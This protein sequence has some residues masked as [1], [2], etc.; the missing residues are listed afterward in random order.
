MKLRIGKKV[1]LQGYDIHALSSKIDCTLQSVLD[2]ALGC[3]VPIFALEDDYE[4]R[5]VVQQPENVQW[6][7]DQDYILDLDTYGQIPIE[8]LKI[9]LEDIYEW[10]D[11]EVKAYNREVDRMRHHAF[12]RNSLYR[13]RHYRRGQRLHKREHRC[14]SLELMIDYLEGQIKF[15]LPDQETTSPVDQEL[16]KEPKVVD[17]TN[18]P[19]I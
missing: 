14:R 1:F 15:D 5:F 3:E 16:N 7:L 10:H 4:F 19:K 9:L 6:L 8:Q 13:Y 11:A 17:L 18:L 2:E 12:Y